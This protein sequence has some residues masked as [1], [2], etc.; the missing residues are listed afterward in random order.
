LPL[1]TPAVVD[2]VGVLVVVV[3]LE[4]VVGL[5]VVIDETVVTGRVVDIELRAAVELD[6]G[7]GEEPAGVAGA[8]PN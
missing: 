1:K 5:A 6:V 4:V 2:G 3:G 8:K 7:G